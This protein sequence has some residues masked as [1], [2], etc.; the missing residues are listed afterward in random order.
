MADMSVGQKVVLTA[1][2][3]ADLTAA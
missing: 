1:A 3:M 2:L